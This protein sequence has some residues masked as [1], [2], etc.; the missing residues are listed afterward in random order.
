MVESFGKFFLGNMD[1][2]LLYLKYVWEDV[3]LGYVGMWERI[4]LVG[5]EELRGL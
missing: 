1:F 2:F 3:G 4:C 5:S